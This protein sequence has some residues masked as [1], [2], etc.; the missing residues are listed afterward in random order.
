MPAER[1][2]EALLLDLQ[3]GEGATAADRLQAFFTDPLFEDA[4]EGVL[5]VARSQLVIVA[6]D[7]LEKYDLTNDPLMSLTA[8]LVEC[9]SN[10][11]IVHAHNGVHIKAFLSA[12][13]F[14]HIKESAVSNTSKFIR[15]E[16]YLT[17][18]PKDLML[19][20]CWRL[21]S[22]LTHRE[23]LP[24]GYDPDSDWRNFGD[25]HAKRWV[26][27][28]GESLKNEFGKQE[29]TFPYVLR[30]IE[31]WPGQLVILCNQIARLAFCAKRFPRMGE[32]VVEAIR[33]AQRRL[34]DEV[35]NSYSEIHPNVALIIDA[36]RGLP[37]RFQG[38]LLDK[39]ARKT[40][41]E[42]QGNYS[43]ANFKRLV[44]NLASSVSNAPST[45]RA[46][47]SKRISST[48]WRSVCRLATTRS[49]S[50]TRC[51]TPNS[52]LIRGRN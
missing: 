33:S 36:L 13:I 5:A 41:S 18:R 7:T 9:A 15:N 45:K 27:Y 17:W 23:L 28:F 52:T 31:M 51:S 11:N 50:F 22:F 8:A 34:A 12:E 42:W 16:L 3:E 35:L 2:A 24:D 26:P 20:V 44:P 6:G 21:D 46:G 14:P 32:F 1:R 19:L 49:A 43:P 4:R 10:F 47:S 29:R 48:R 25:V 40:A 39:V 30:H 38:N 37:M